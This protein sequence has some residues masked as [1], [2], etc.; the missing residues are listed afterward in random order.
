MSK[1][2]ASLSVTSNF[3]IIRPYQDWLDYILS[4]P[5]PPLAISTSYG[6][7]EQTGGHI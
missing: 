4:Q 3:T 7:D 6:D 2:K 5:N 1:A